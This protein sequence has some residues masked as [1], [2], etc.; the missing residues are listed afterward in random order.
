[1]SQIA[2]S[3]ISDLEMPRQTLLNVISLLNIRAFNNFKINVYE[4]G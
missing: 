2:A 3:F 1:M 4:F